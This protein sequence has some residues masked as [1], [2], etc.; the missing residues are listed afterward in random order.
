MVARGKE[1][2]VFAK[3]LYN[4]DTGRFIV[5]YGAFSN[6]P[7]CIGVGDTP[8]EAFEHLAECVDGPGGPKRR[9][10][11]T[12]RKGNETS[13]SFKVFHGSEYRVVVSDASGNSVEGVGRNMPRALYA[14]SEAMESKVKQ[15]SSTG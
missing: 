3:F 2:D 13:V 10:R 15:D 7:T 5:G 4:E 1:L 14:L 6:R 8:K 11:R 12:L 9:V